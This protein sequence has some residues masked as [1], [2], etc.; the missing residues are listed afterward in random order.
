MRSLTWKRF[1]MMQWLYP[2]FVVYSAGH[3][4]QQ[5][6]SIVSCPH[7]STNT[8]LLSPSPAP[9]SP[10]WWFPQLVTLRNL[11]HLSLSALH[12]LNSNQIRPSLLT[13]DNVLVKTNVWFRFWR[14]I[15]FISKQTLSTPS[16]CLGNNPT[17][18]KIFSCQKWWD[19]PPLPG[20]FNC[21]ADQSGAHY[22]VSFSV[23]KII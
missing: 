23:C 13:V 10:R 18:I 3:Y 7:T 17:E 14:E 8:V 6:V 22:R 2:C 20:K 21:R 5:D 16:C 19:L 11:I 15:Y 9:P 1:L 12:M 4:C